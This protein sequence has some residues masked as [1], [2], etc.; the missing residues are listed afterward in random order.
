MH[1]KTQRWL[2][3]A[4]LVASTTALQGCASVVPVQGSTPWDPRGSAQLFDQIPNWEGAAGRI[5][6]GHLKSC[7]SHQSPRC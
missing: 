5:C 2:V 7:Q 4:A 6:C 3:L 1:T